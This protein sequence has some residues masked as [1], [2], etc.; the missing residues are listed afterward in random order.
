MEQTLVLNASYEPISIVHWQRAMTLFFKG[1]AEIVAEHDIEKRAVTFSFKLPAVVRLLRFVRVRGKREGVPFSRANI[2][3]RDDYTCQYCG[4]QKDAEDL[5]FDHVIPASKGGPKCWEN[6]VTAC[7]EC[8]R[9][10]ADRTPEDAGMT[11][12]RQPRRPH[13]SPIFRVSLGLRRTPES[14]LNY[15]YWNVELES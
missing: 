14:W 11:L 6:I 5:N 9:T 13:A 10:K 2:F 3:R 15:L 1:A 7:L 12:R 8:N 4:E